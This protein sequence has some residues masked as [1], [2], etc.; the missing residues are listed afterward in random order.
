MKYEKMLSIA[1]IKMLIKSD[2]SFEF[3][4]RCQPFNIESNEKD[5]VLNLKFD[6]KMIPDGRTIS[7]NNKEFIKCIGDRN[8]T[9]RYADGNIDNI[10]WFSSKESN[11]PVKYDIH[12][13][14]R[15]KCDSHMT[16]NPMFYVNLDDF[17]IEFNAV[18]LHSSYIKYRDKGILFTAPSG[19]GKSTQAKLWEKNKGAEIVNGDRTIIRKKEKFMVYG[20]PYAGS[21]QIYKNIGTE[22][23]AI[24]VLRQG[25]TNNITRMNRKKAYLCLLSET[26]LSP[27]NKNTID[28]QS[29][30]LL[31]LVETIPVY[32]LE[33][34]PDTGAVELLSSTLE[35]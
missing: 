27:S 26:S 15:N 3:T 1:D 22:L 28:L 18:I 10:V 4:D 5:V 9:F 6:E 29:K 19:V 24:V 7:K 33:C 13:C 31:E 30:L 21:S 2:K 8:I 35:T 17:F 23:E 14:N 34:L 20:S 16:I 32:L 11:N 12:I 25:K